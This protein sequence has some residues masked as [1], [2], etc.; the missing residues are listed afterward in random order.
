MEIII[1]PLVAITVLVVM[2]I[3]FKWR[4]RGADKIISDYYNSE[5]FDVM[6]I[7]NLSF[8]ECI[9]YRAP[10]PFISFFISVYT[11][12]YTP[13]KDKKYF[14]RLELEHKSGLEFFIYIECYIQRG[15]LLEV[16]ELDVVE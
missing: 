15:E 3:L 9:R 7:D 12:L 10:M 16:T 8:N 11:T 1:A 14:R 13:S 2:Y 6:S 4:S 5:G